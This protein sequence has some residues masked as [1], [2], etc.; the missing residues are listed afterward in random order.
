MS[1]ERVE[2]GRTQEECP[3][4]LSDVIPARMVSHTVR[5]WTCSRPGEVNRAGRQQYHL[6]AFARCAGGRGPGFLGKER[7]K[8]RKGRRWRPP[9]EERLAPR[10]ARGA[11]NRPI[12]GP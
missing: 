5:T 11:T 2:I 3:S 4:R 1:G 12:N 8:R 9:R 6:H 7:Y 10:Q